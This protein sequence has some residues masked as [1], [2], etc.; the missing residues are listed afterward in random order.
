MSLFAYKTVT[1][2]APAT[3]AVPVALP[4]LTRPDRDQAARRG[5]DFASTARIRPSRHVDLE[6][7]IM[8]GTGVQ[9][10]QGRALNDRAG[11]WQMCTREAGRRAVHARVAPGTRPRRAGHEADEESV[12]YQDAPYRR[13]AEAYPTSGTW[14]AA[15]ESVAAS[16][17]GQLGLLPEPGP[18][19]APSLPG[20]AETSRRAAQDWGD[21]GRRVRRRATFVAGQSRPLTAANCGLR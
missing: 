3:A 13:H 5:P 9:P 19:M 8:Y 10:V 18:G 20:L 6:R 11:A 4:H 16:D 12:P 2:G 21:A 1:K 7:T 15:D 17:T 14:R